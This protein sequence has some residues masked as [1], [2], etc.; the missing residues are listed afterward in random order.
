MRN[1]VQRVVGKETN[2]GGSTS[3]MNNEYRKVYDIYNNILKFSHLAFALKEVNT[4]RFIDVNDEFIA[5]FEY[6]KQ[7]ILR[8]ED[9]LLRQEGNQYAAIAREITLLDGNIP[10]YT[11]TT[12]FQKKDGTFFWG[13]TTRSVIEADGIKYI[14]ISITD[15]TEQKNIEVRL[16][17]SEKMYRQLFDHSLNTIGVYDI[18]SHC[19]IDCN[20]TFTQVYGYKRNE[21]DSLSAPDLAWEE[22]DRSDPVYQQRYQENIDRLR[23]NETIRFESA[24]RSKEGKKIIVD[25]ILIPF[26]EEE[27]LYIKQVTT[28]ITERRQAR[29]KLQQKMNE[30]EE[31]NVSLKKYIESNLQ[32]EN[33]AHITSHDLR[34]PINTII[35]FSK[36]LKQKLSEKLS[37]K[38]EKYVEFLITSGTKLKNMIDDILA[39]SKVNQDNVSFENIDTQ[40]LINGVLLD[41]NQMIDEK[42]AIINIDKHLPQSIIG[43]ASYIYQLCQNLI[44]NAIKFSKPGENPIVSIH[45]KCLNTHHQF[46]IEDNGIGIKKE[47]FDKI[48]LIFQ[49]LNPNEKYNGSGIGLAVCK[50][51][52]ELHQGKIWVESEVGEGT[53]FYFTIAKKLEQ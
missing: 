52:V 28:D 7:E 9:F 45:Y 50:K 10:K 5:L 4:R 38:E 32:L 37:P 46:C 29:E 47:F 44:K 48:F 21:L 2:P 22:I 16:S 13:Q 26:Y 3:G 20:R 34:E 30:L 19:F 24:H 36:I 8:D 43:H 17:K 27:K 23:A 18:D 49:K 11:R 15:I 31:V 39:F 12:K 51:V 1:D 41:L 40:E 35:S 53:R 25:V 14:I 42:K 6:S 33:F